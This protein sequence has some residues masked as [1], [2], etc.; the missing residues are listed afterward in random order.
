MFLLLFYLS[1]ISFEIPVFGETVHAQEH[2]EDCPP[3]LCDK[4]EE[5]K[6]EQEEEDCPPEMCGDVNYLII[7]VTKVEGNI[8]LHAFGLKE[9]KTCAECNIN[10]LI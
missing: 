7:F 1:P 2:E 5:E 3:E 6:T 8:E 10:S 4:D 9:I